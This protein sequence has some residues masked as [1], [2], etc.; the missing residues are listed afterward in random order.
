ME[1]ETPEEQRFLGLTATQLNLT[2]LGIVGGIAL[3]V[4]AY[5]GGADAVSDFFGDDSAPAVTSVDEGTPTPQPAEGDDETPPE[6]TPD[7]E[8]DETATPPPADPV[9]VAAAQAAADAAVLTL[10]DLPAGWALAP[11]DDEDAGDEFG[12]GFDEECASEFDLSFEDESFPGEIAGA[13]SAEFE[14]PFG[15]SASNTV[16]VF[17]NEGTA[18]E[19]VALF[20]EVFA[21]CAGEFEKLLLE[22]FEEEAQA[23]GE[24]AIDWQVDVTM[25]KVPFYH[26]GQQTIAHRLSGSMTTD[27][28]TFEFA[29]DFAMYRE[30]RVA[31][32]F[33]FFTLFGLGVDEEEPIAETTAQKLRD[34]NALLGG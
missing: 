32:M 16:S 1:Q 31:G 34:A 25:E 24:D 18:M 11:Q 15:Q 12:E 9:D 28:F 21:A 3:G 5:F 8:D 2:V 26:M 13:E 33:T 22:G 19:A 20:D 30:G 17:D 10:A 7:G 27:G 14:G 23:D 6:A 4:G 29:L